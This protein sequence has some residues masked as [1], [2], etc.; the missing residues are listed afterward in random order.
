MQFIEDLKDLSRDKIK[1]FISNILADIK[2][3]KNVLIKHSDYARNDFT[4]DI[5][6]YLY[7]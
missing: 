4:N 6:I 1:G 5:R 3:T 7:M 2:M